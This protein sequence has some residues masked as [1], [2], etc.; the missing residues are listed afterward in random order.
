MTTYT[1]PFTKWLRTKL[2]TVAVLRNGNPF[3][4][5]F[6]TLDG[7]VVEGVWNQPQARLEF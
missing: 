4:V 2:D 3:T 6:N 5:T 7:L 1:I